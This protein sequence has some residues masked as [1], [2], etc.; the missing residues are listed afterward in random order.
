MRNSSIWVALASVLLFAGTASASTDINGLFD[1][2][3]HGMGGTGVAYINSAAAV[4]INPALLDGVKKLTITLDVVGIGAQ[5]QAPYTIWH[6]DD[7]GQPYQSYDTIRSTRALAPLPF[8]GVAYRLHPR[9]VLALAAYPVIGQG[10]AAKY[11]P[12]PDQYPNLVAT[13]KASMGLIET[14]E[15][16]SIRLLDNLSIAL[17]WR[18]TY[19]T[20]Q[21]SSPLPSNNSPGVISNADKTQVT[22]ADIDVTGLNFYGFQFGVAYKPVPS[23]SLGFT[24]RNKV[25]VQGTGFTTVTVLGK[26]NKFETKSGFTNPHSFRGGLAWSVLNDKLLLAMDVKYLLYAEAF[27]QLKTTVQDKPKP[28][29]PT[30]NTS[31]QYWKNSAVLQLG[32]EYKTTDWLALRAG[33]TVLNSATRAD[34][35][36]AFG[37]P[38]GISHLITGGLGFKVLDSLDVDVAGSYVVLEGRVKT[39]TPDNAG[40]GLYAAHGG[41]IS[42]SATYH[43]Q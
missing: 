37:A 22:N 42:L 40:P 31:N 32:A 28:A 16:L 27:K 3:S 43:S 33:Y 17:M 20:Q 14:G 29:K 21:V 15:A 38:P 24:Y 12:A 6:L 2:R 26:P 34:Y 30:V 4:P 10:T 1:A 36:I 9:L 13:N 25:D 8:L 35:A 19:M 18:I 11:K 41:M 39:K 23:L 5:P 7:N